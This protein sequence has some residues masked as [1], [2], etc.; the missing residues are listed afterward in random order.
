MDIVRLRILAKNGD[1]AAA[2]ALAFL[3]E[4]K[5]ITER[6]GEVVQ[7]LYEIA[8]REIP[9][10][11]CEVAKILSRDPVNISIAVELLKT[12]LNEGVGR[13]GTILALMY[14][15][16]MAPTS[17]SSDAE[18]LLLA[19]AGLGDPSACIELARKHK[20]KFG[21][22]YDRQV[23][24]DYLSEAFRGGDNAAA[25]MLADWYFESGS[26]ED[27]K[28]ALELLHVGASRD[29]FACLVKLSS[30]YRHGMYGVPSDLNVAKRYHE[31]SLH[32]IGRPIGL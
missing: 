25:S 28:R 14:D 29:D 32:L 7:A 10:A 16:G 22:N 23:I 27:I 1:S 11:K 18:K 12:A 9:L 8:G 2:F 21:K 5:L 3:L 24:Y 26:D 13:A 30:I 4:N 6:P 17:N 19:A 31:K 15:S 20:A